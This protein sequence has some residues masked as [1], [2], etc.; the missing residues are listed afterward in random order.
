[1]GDFSDLEMPFH[2][3]N[4]YLEED[5]AIAMTSTISSL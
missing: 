5:T 2:P 4:Y 1:M 3:S